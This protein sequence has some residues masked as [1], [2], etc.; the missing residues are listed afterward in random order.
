MVAKCNAL[1]APRRRV[2]LSRK[3]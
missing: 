2:C 1:N 3:P